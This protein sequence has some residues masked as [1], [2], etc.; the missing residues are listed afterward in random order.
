MKLKLDANGNAVLQDGKPV[1][2]NDDGSEVAFDAAGMSASIKRLNGEAMGH[3]QRA[4]EAEG[5]L[6]A[7]EGIDATAARE[8][9]DKLSKMDQKKL[10]DAGEVEAVRNQVNAGWQTKFDAKEAEVQ[11]LQGQLH[12]ELI[13]G[14]F[15]R[16]KF[17]TEK[18]VIP[19]DMAQAAFGSAFK[20]VDGKIVAFGADK[21]PI[22][23]KSNPGQHADFDEAL[24]TLVNAYPGKDHI[25]KGNGAAGSGAQASKSGGHTPGNF[26]GSTADRVNAIKN[27]FPELN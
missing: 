12:G 6:K 2:I 27:Q 4:E 23:S 8:A 9:F 1:Y 26:G 21:Q 19:A 10:I 5:K 22:F 16:S 15:A 17:L 24:E 7:F 3:R 13:G 18:M 20:V 14:G 11:A 25:M